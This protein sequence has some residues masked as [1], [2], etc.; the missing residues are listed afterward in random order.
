MFKLEQELTK[1]IT[2]PIKNLGYKLL[3][4]KFIHRRNSIFRIYIDSKNGITVEDCANV[5]QK[6]SNI[7]NTKNSI[8][9][10]YRFEVSSPG[11]NRPLFTA[12]Q[13]SEYIGKEATILLRVP[14]KNRKRWKV[15]IGTVDNDMITVITNGKSTAFSFNN[16]Q[17]AN[18]VPNF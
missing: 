3:G 10:A 2:K 7:L 15:I 8:Y 14:V 5:S 11:F 9:V 17:K 1:I 6:V 16:I 4:I 12:A 18:L 13:F